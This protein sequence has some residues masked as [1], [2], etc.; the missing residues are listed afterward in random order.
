MNPHRSK[1]A[2][3]MAL[4]VAIIVPAL[5]LL[6]ARPGT[7]QEKAGAAA[8]PSRV[9]QQGTAESH[10][11]TNFPL[12]G[13]HR[14]LACREC[15]INLVF[16]G[17]PT[18]CEV[19]HWQ[20]RQD[21]RYSLR[22]GTRCAD[23]HTPQSW[24]K[25]DPA[26][27]SHETNVGYKLEGVHRT[28]DC[29]ACHGSAGFTA[30]S[31]DCLSCHE[32]DYRGTREPNHVEAGFPTT[33]PSCHSQRSW[34]DA[35]FAHTGFLRQGRHASA[36]CSDCHKNGVFQGTPSECVSCHLADYNSTTDPNHRTAGF[37][38]DCSACHGT[39]ATGWSGANF[40]H[41]FPIQ[42]G[43]HAVACSECHQTSDFRVFNCLGCHEKPTT[44]SHHT[45]VTG[46]SYNS[47]ACYACHPHGSGG[48]PAAR[49][50]EAPPAGR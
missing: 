49:P 23:C 17:T 12:T 22:L 31:P 5:L 32:S 30:R 41:A 19:C 1:S 20:R 8:K 14:T 3:A 2:P 25:V 26:L 27:W 48:G 45:G 37:P 21:D 35:S 50:A 44:D 33:C 28:L 18:D 40:D 6:A 43:R 13:K 11:R 47:Q 24:K 38:L 34:S 7:G 46:Y 39:A 36:A 15:H 9:G 10:D 16:E 42:S 29:E 4:A